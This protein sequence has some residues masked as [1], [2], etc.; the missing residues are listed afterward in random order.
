MSSGTIKETIFANRDNV[1]RLQLLEDG[2]LF[3]DKYP[4]V[5]VSR[6]VF[7]LNTTVPIVVDSQI[8]AGAFIWTLLTSTL[9]LKLGSTI[10]SAIDYTPTTLVLY[11]TEWPNG[12]VWINPTCT[13]SKLSI[14]VCNNS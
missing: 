6:W 7:T 5:V 14:R 8:T 9:E 4:E 3:F 12:L 11:S 10:L 2:V 13:P 1:I